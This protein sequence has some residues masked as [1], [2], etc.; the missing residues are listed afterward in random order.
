MDPSAPFEVAFCAELTICL[1]EFCP[2][3]VA[4][5]APVSL[6]TISYPGGNSNMPPATPAVPVG[7][8]MSTGGTL[9]A[10]EKLEGSGVG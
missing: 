2:A 8:C 7:S 6:R 5:P 10:A 4:A 1:A 3:A 9:G